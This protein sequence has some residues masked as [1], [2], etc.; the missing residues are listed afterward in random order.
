MIDYQIY[1]E[2]DSIIGLAEEDRFISNMSSYIEMKEILGNIDEKNIEMVENI[3]EWITI[4]EDKK[5]L[6]RKIKKEYHLDDNT[7]EKLAKKNYN[8]WSRLS[9]KLL[10]EMK[11][12][13]D[14]KSVMEKLKST[15]EN[16]M[17][18]INNT[19]YGFDKQ[20]EEKMREKQKDNIT[21]GEVN[22]IPTSPANKRLFGNA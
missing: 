15:R 6:K 1:K 7:I 14:N 10:T 20:I 22:E 4:F 12:Y 3:I 17:Q 19:K 5:I 18:I 2:V 8:G 9:K 11:S 16:F 21:Y 13:D